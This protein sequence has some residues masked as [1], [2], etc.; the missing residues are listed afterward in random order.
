MRVRSPERGGGHRR[1]GNKLASWWPA[2]GLK[3]SPGGGTG[4]PSRGLILDWR[5]IS[6][7]LPSMRRDLSR[8]SFNSTRHQVRLAC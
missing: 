3:T 5:R 4:T 2:E 6:C 7:A 8:V 1:T